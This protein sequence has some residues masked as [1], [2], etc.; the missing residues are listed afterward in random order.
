MATGMARGAFARGKRIAFGDGKR[1]IWSQHCVN[2]FKGNNNIC[3]PGQERS[4]TTEWIAYHKGNR[5]YNKQGKGCWVWNYDFRAIPGEI[6]LTREEE[7]FAQQMRHQ[8]VLIEPNVP[9]FKSTA[10]NKTW[11]AERYDEVARQL[12]QAGYHVLQLHH[13]GPLSGAVRLKNAA[14]LRSPNF[15]CALALMQQASLYVGPE[16]GLH[17][18]A[19]A[20]GTPGV[21]LFGGFIPPEITGYD[22]HTN[23]TGNSTEACGSLKRCNHCIAAMKSIEVEEVVEAAL[24][25]LR[26][27]A[28]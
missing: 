6:F 27:Q 11:P 1:L 3:F 24:G 21:V 28:A 15:R 5:I 9:Q 7:K 20:M 8:F 26:R 12:V 4:R 2:I 18:G 19:A 10:P 14:L 23:L 16:G 25:H 22:S 13:S 17:H